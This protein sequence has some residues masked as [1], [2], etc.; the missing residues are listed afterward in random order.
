[1]GEDQMPPKDPDY[2]GEW[3]GVSS[4]LAIYDDFEPRIMT[5][6]MSSSITVTKEGYF[7]TLSDGKPITAAVDL[8]N[9]LVIGTGAG[10]FT[11]ASLVGDR[12]VV[13]SIDA[14]GHSAGSEV[15]TRMPTDQQA[16]PDGPGAEPD[17][18]PPGGE[19]WMP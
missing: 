15:Y 11:V 19:A 7:Y 12:L 18:L 8:K 10:T 17:N 4:S 16:L 2:Q 5:V 13:G 9:T 6:D 3:Y 14:N 1:M